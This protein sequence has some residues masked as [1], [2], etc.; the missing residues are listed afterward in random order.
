MPARKPSGTL[1]PS[2]LCYRKRFAP[3]EDDLSTLSSVITQA[4]SFPNDLPL[5]SRKVEDILGT[6]LYSRVVLYKSIVHKVICYLSVDNLA[7]Y[8]PTVVKE[9]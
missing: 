8:L 5:F 7:I 6:I 9:G 4:P 1:W 3:R 2:L